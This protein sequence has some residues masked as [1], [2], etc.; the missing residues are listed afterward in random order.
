LA[1]KT[2]RAIELYYDHVLPKRFTF[3]HILAISALSFCLSVKAQERDGWQ[4]D[5]LRANASVLKPDA[6]QV[7]EVLLKMLDRW[8]A[9]DIEGYMKVYSNSP[10]L[11]VVIDSEQFNGWQQLHD[12]Y[13]NAYPD[14]NG[15][16][17]IDPKRI[18][19]KLLKPDLALA[20]TWWSVSFPNSKQ[21]VVGNTTMDLQKSDDGRK[22]IASHTSIT[23]R[24]AAN[25]RVSP[26]PA[27]ALPASSPRPTPTPLIMNEGTNLYN[28]DSTQPFKN[29]RKPAGQ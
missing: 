1:N 26:S 20:L 13:V 23:G 12:S 4:F 3:V 11:L 10:E 21:K 7:Y 8:N 5:A 15:R 14:R 6:Q 22:I 27:T 16:G 2:N 29:Y 17:F 24:P 18:K 25:P 19:I 9:H 28:S